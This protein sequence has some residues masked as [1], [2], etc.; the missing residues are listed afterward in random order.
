[1]RSKNAI[2]NLVIYLTYEVLVFVLGFIFPRYIILTYGSEVNGLTS[3]ITRLLAL[4]NLIQAGAVGAAIYQMY[5]PV[6]DN[7]Y[8]TQ[9]A[10]IYSSKKYYNKITIIYLCLATIFGVFYSFYLKNENLSFFEILCSFA[11][12]ASNGSFTLYFNSISDIFLSPH[13]KKYYLTISSIFRQLVTYTLMTVVL[14]F[15]QHFIFL[16]CSLLI[17]GVAGSLLN[18]YF[19]EKIS[20]GLIKKKPQVKNYVISGRKYL[21]LSSIGKQAVVAS[22][23]IIV[24]TFNGLAYASVFSIYAMIFTS[25][26]TLL[27]SIQLSVS[28]IFGNLVKSSYD[29]HIFEVY[30][31]IQLFT[32]LLGSIFVFC[33]G[34]LLIPFINIYVKDVN[35]INYLYPVLAYLIVAY[36]AFFTFETSFGYVATV[37]GLFKVTCKIT[38]LFGCIG[39]LASI[40]SVYFWGMPFVM[41]GLLFYQFFCACATL[42]VLHKNVSWFRIERLF[43]RSLVLFTFSVLGIVLFHLFQSNIDSILSWLLHGIVCFIMS[44]IVL[45]IYCLIFERK[46]LVVI[47]NYVKK[48][49]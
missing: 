42:F 43:K 2:K 27:N 48:L 23:Q 39:I 30:D 6:A 41:V 34:F 36:T 20:H 1:M 37:Y 8:E 26:Q 11:I 29:E 31:V 25:M 19:F 38:L 45:Y 9:S 14:F 13:Q 4:I 10:I 5:K 17:G 40:I 24:T 16:Y 47:K 44:C 3:T 18:I 33:M 49:K 46:Q 28:A 7:D 35:D 22:P 15:K 21:M 32:I 12:L